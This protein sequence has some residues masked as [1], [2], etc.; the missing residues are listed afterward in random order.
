MTPGI[1][2][3]SCV[4]GRFRRRGWRSVALL[5]VSVAVL[6]SAGCRSGACT[7]MGCVPKEIAVHL[8]ALAVAGAS[9]E[10]TVDACVGD[11]CTQTSLPASTLASGA[12][13]TTPELREGGVSFRRAN[14]S[15]A[16]TD[17]S[18]CRA[19]FEDRAR[20]RVTTSYPNGRG[21]SPA[22]VSG[23]DVHSTSSA[24]G[25]RARSRGAPDRT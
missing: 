5:L 6:T 7:D 1:G 19:L 13:V 24:T 9:E 20:A 12:I 23:Q 15:V 11:R 14:V 21:C 22:C 3:R 17:P 2:S 8:P 4:L 16:V 18:G 10:L 25:T